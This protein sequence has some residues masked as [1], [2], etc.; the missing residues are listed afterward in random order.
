MGDKVILDVRR[1]LRDRKFWARYDE[2]RT[3]GPK[4]GPSLFGNIIDI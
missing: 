2:S 4:G 1:D 3:P